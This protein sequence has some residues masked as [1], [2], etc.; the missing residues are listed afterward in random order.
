MVVQ[1]QKTRL[2]LQLVAYVQH[3]PGARAT[4]D[5]LLSFAK[6]QITERAAIPLYSLSRTAGW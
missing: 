4:E 1:S 3:R 2:D 6:D 5:E